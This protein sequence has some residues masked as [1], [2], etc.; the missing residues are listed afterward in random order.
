MLLSLSPSSLRGFLEHLAPASHLTWLL[1]RPLIDRPQMG[2]RI[3]KLSLFY[4]QEQMN[5]FK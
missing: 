4:Q 3:D 2:G 5:Q 1:I